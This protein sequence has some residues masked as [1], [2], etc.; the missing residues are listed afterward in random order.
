MMGDLNLALTII[1]N[2]IDKDKLTEGLGIPDF[3]F[4][5]GDKLILRQFECGSDPCVQLSKFY[6]LNQATSHETLFVT[7]AYIHMMR[8]SQFLMYDDLSH[9]ELPDLSAR[10]RTVHVVSSRH[11][12]S[13]R[14]MGRP[15][16]P[17]DPCIE[18]FRMLYADDMEVR[19]G[20]NEAGEGREPA[21][22]LPVETA[23]ALLLN[24]LYGGKRNI[25]SC[26]LMTD[27]QY[28]NAES[29]LIS[30]LTTMR[31]REGGH[32]EP[33]VNSGGECGEEDS[34]DDDIVR[35]VNTEHERAKAEFM[36]Y[37]MT[38]KP[39]KNVPR[40]YVG[41]PLKFGNIS[42]GKVANRGYDIKA[43]H[44]FVTCNLADFIC[45]KGHFDLVAFLQLQREA[46]PTLFK[47]AVCLASIRTNEVGCERFFSTAGYVSC[48]RRTSLKVRNYECLATLKVNMQ[49]VFIDERWV[50]NQ[51]LMMDQK[52]EWKQLDTDNDMNVL[53]L[54]RE[55]LA[56]SLG[57]PIDTLPNISEPDHILEPEVIDLDEELCT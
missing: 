47:L 37:C 28:D 40:A 38:V 5:P 21:T 14:D 31:E 8:Q 35:P 17:M 23:I 36:S 26:G 27:E 46:Y 7:A 43:S 48:P 22:K 18:L 54:E 15:E 55:M 32:V 13:E 12:T 41:S 39:R 34:L 42:M 16:Q 24:P 3:T 10:K 2:G 33:T 57:V 44:P 11:V 49:H 51:Y 6:Q 45:D 19:C 53:N 9:S 56:E 52:R 29:D 4:T 30:R 25:T 50:V 20:F 1:I